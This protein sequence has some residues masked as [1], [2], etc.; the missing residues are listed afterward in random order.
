MRFCSRNCLTYELQYTGQSWLNFMRGLHT[1]D[2]KSQYISGI[3][4]Y[5]RWLN[6]DS[7]DK[8]L[9]GNAELLENQI[10]GFIAAQKEKDL[11]TYIIKNRLA[12]IKKFYGMNRKPLSWDFIYGTVG[13]NKKKS[14]DEAYTHEQIRNMLEVADLREKAIIMLL[15][16]TGVRRG[17]IPELEIG[18]LFPIDD[19]EIYKIVVYRGY[20]E[21]YKTYCTR[22][23][24]VIFDKYLDYRRSVGEKMDE[25]TPLIRNR[26]DDRIEDQVKNAKGIT[27][28]TINHLVSRMAVKVGIRQKVIMT[29]GQQGGSIRYRIKAIHGFRKFFDTQCTLA[30]VPPLWVEMLEGH[31][32]KLKAHYLRPTE[33]DLLEGNDQVP[34][35]V[36]AI[37][38]LTID[39]ANKLRK[40]VKTLEAKAVSDAEILARITNIENNFGIKLP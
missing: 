6:I 18:N 25:A 28:K 9:E 38:A 12:A 24:R 37:D 13:R 15:A 33:N 27:G 1:R 17:A 10:I 26:F 39:E 29:E 16:T 7:P 23:A 36:A 4:I 2:T 22:E 14:K 19:Y 21:E 3:R 8:L 20:P 11:S 40:R 30:G 32:I 5:M 31:D 34:G 35:Y